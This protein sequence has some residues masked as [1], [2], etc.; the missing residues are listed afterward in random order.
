MQYLKLESW[1]V[2]KDI[3]PIIVDLGQLESIELEFSLSHKGGGQVRLPRTVLP[4]RHYLA[5][6]NELNVHPYILENCPKC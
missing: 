5:K 1:V 2:S 6:L 3:I 4:P